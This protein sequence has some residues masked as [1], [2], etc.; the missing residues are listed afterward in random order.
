ML[1]DIFNLDLVFIIMALVV[2]IA[3]AE[4]R[5]RRQILEVIKTIH[6]GGQ[7]VPPEVWERLL[8]RGGNVTGGSAWTLPI[9]LASAAAGFMLAAAPF[10]IEWREAKLFL[11]FALTCLVA[12]AGTAL[13]ARSRRRNDEE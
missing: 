12:A 13:V 9:V 2:P 6:A 1:K 11:A 4:D 3:W 7:I 10:P 5:R 8:Q